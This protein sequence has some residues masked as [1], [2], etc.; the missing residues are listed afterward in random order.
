[1]TELHCPECGSKDVFSTHEQAFMINTG[2]HYGHMTNDYDSNSKSGCIV[3]G[4]RGERSHLVSN[5]I[6]AAIKEKNH[7]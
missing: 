4:W 2:D 3:C 1:V 7:D 6:E 5:T